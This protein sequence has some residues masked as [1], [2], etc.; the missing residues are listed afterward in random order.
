MFIIEFSVLYSDTG[1]W[2]EIVKF[3][4]KMFSIGITIWFVSYVFVTCLNYA[5]ER[6]VRP[7]DLSEPGNY[8]AGV[9]D[10]DGVPAGGAKAGHGLVRHEVHSGLRHPPHRVRCKDTK[11]SC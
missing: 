1:L 10:P 4:E 8:P 3:S 6:Q 5:A 2:T 9:P 7:E 11:R